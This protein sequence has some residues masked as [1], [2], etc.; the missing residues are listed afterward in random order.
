MIKIKRLVII[1]K[2][3][4]GYLTDTYKYCQH[5]RDNYD[6]TYVC[7]DMGLEKIDMDKVNIKYFTFNN[8]ISSIK[9]FYNFCIYL[10]QFLKKENFNF[11]FCVY[12]RFCFLIPL[13]I[14]NNNIWLDIRT[15]CI[16]NSFFRRLVSNSELIFNSLFFKNI[17]VIS[18]GVANQLKLKK[19]KLLPLGA[20]SLPKKNLLNSNYNKVK[21]LYIGTFEY[22]EIWKTIIAYTKV[23]SKFPTIVDDYIIIGSGSAKEMEKI[24]KSIDQFDVGDNVKLMGWVEHSKLFS[25]LDDATVGVSFIPITNYFNYQPPTKTFEYLMN[26]LVCIGTN[27]YEN[28]KII[29]DSNGV[30]CQDTVVD[31]EK[32]I[33]KICYNISNFSK[34][35]IITSMQDKH[36]W[37]SISKKFSE[38]IEKTVNNE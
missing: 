4:F 8:K 33:E 5:L 10:L 29:N 28:R 9:N 35:Q 11:I 14:K 31:F 22:R 21:L 6:I 16:S 24:K 17:S 32:A 36:S 3:Q 15:T 13:F 20:D 2:D 26:G 30:L 1:S 37:R 38:I 12:F 23:K 7:F 34:K 18:D 27:T 19:Y 25:Y